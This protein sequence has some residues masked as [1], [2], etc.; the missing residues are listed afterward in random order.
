M[1]FSLFLIELW[2]KKNNPLI[3]LSVFVF[4]I[5]YVTVPFI[6]MVQITII[7]NNTFPLLAG[8]FILTWV[9][10]TFAYLSGL[11]AG[12]TKLF[13]RVSPKKTSEGTI[14][15]AVFTIIASIIIGYLFDN[16]HMIFWILVSLIIIPCAVLGDLMESLFKRSMNLKDTGNIMPGHGG[17]LDRFD[18]T[19]FVVPFFLMCW[20]IYKNFA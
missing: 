17:I 7:D 14:G 2:R 8:M 12:K 20:I 3:N 15:G 11:I 19:F 10:D 4:G 5:I 13:E 1:L 9:N 18:S 6:L 16:E